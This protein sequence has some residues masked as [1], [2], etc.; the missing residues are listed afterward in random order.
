MSWDGTERRGAETNQ[1]LALQEQMNRQDAILFE[2]RDAIKEHLT[3]SKDIGPAL[4]E[5]VV[6][7]KASKLLGSIIAFFAAGAAGLWSLFVWA[8]DHLK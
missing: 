1:Y 3:E 4:K 8:K 7:W 6:L 2:L 5:L